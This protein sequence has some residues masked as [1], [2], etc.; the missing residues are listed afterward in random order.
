MFDIYD[1]IIKSLKKTKTEF[2]DNLTFSFCNNF[3]QMV[4]IIETSYEQKFKLISCV[5]ITLKSQ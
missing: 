1:Q 4:S 3:T 2:Y 5:T